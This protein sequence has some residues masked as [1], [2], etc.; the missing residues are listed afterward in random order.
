MAS[1]TFLDCRATNQHGVSKTV[2][3]AD[4]RSWSCLRSTRSRESYLTTQLRAGSASG[5]E[6]RVVD[7]LRKSLD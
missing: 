6:G 7:F 1:S 5:F 4:E 2:L 3:A